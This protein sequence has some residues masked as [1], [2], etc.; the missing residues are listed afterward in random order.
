M[1]SKVYCQIEGL[2]RDTNIKGK[3]TYAVVLLEH[4]LVPL[5]LATHAKHLHLHLL[6]SSLIH[7]LELHLL[8]HLLLPCELLLLKSLLFL[9]SSELLGVLPLKSRRFFLLTSL[10]SLTLT[11]QCLLLGLVFAK[12]ALLLL[13]VGCRGIK[14]GRLR[15]RGCRGL[16]RSG[17]GSFGQF[18]S[19]PVVEKVGR[20]LQVE[21]SRCIQDGERASEGLPCLSRPHLHSNRFQ[22]TWPSFGTLM[23]PVRYLRFEHS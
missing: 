20:F 13:D 7:L 8:L 5:I 18:G 10:S 19:S 17:F 23:R 4:H 15:G 16:G 22:R 2:I 9:L 1:R 6:L 14:D 11:N 21:A 3:T 12:H